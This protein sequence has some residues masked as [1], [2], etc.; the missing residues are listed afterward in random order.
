MSSNKE[1]IQ[2]N[3]RLGYLK[4]PQIIKAFEIIDRKDFVTK[5]NQESVYLNIPLSIGFGQTI[6]QPLTVAFMLELLQPQIGD[7]ILDIGSG[8]GWTSALLS[9][10][11]SN[12]GQNLNGKIIAIELIPELKE[13]GEKN[14]IKYNFVKRNIVKFFCADGATEITDILKKFDLKE[15]VDK[16]LCS[17]AL[18]K[19]PQQWLDNLKIGGKIVSPFKGEIQLWTKQNKNNYLKEFF[20]G[21][22]FVPCISKEQNNEE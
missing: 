18:S 19:M 7:I 21:F 11:V 8:S 20:T 5:N 22:S 2:E 4:S 6:S 1:L 14:V 10:L 9:Y 13:F 12:N 17:A 16:I 3:I 15:K